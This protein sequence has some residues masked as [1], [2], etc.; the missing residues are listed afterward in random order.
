M[1]TSTRGRRS[2]TTMVTF[3]SCPRCSGDRS[4]EHDFDGW[5]IVCLYCGHVA[6]PEVSIGEDGSVSRVSEYGLSPAETNLGPLI[7]LQRARP[8]TTL[9]DATTIS[10]G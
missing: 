5:Y 7:A 4:L 2:A 1:V 3:K 8:R 6:Y 10:G 9:R